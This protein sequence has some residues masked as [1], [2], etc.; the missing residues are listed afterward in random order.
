[1]TLR[2]L[3]DPI[4]PNQTAFLNRGIHEIY[5]EESGNPK[6]HPVVFLHGGPGCGTGPTARRFFDPNFYRIILFDQRGSGQSKPQACLEDNNTEA[7]ISDMEAIRELLN[8]DRWLVFGGSWGSTL[9]LSYA[10]KHPDRVVGLILRGIFLGRQE[11]IDWIYQAGGAGNIF[12]EAFAAYASQIPPEERGDLIMAYYK[13]LTS[14]DPDTKLRAAKAWSAWEGAITTLRPNQDQTDTFTQPDYALNMASIECHFWVNHMFTD[15]MNYILDQAHIIEAIPTHIVHGRYD[16][17][18]RVI[19]AYLLAAKLR[20]V[21]LE[22]PICG[23]SST[24]PEI[25]DSLVRA[26]DKFKSLF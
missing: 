24:E 3:Y 12:P 9:A 11:D 4:E 10:I 1:M 18:C 20:Q 8:I 17:D 6:G 7:L 21:T 13:R 23:H 26:T 22:V 14:A 25:I 5:Y 19:G 15:N 2:S 16:M